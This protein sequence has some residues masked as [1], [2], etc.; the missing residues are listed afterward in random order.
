MSKFLYCRPWCTL[1]S[2]LPPYGHSASSVVSSAS[3]AEL[4][5]CR[6]AAESDAL[7]AEAAFFGIHFHTSALAFAIGG[8]DGASPLRTTEMLEGISGKWRQATPLLTER[9]YAAC[10][11]ILHKIVAAGGQN[12]DYKVTTHLAERCAMLLQYLLL[13]W[14]GSGFLP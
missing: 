10:S 4:V 3:F 7:A 14:C 6:D 13:L 1:Q 5:F 11:A 9:A 2:N 12:L 8:H